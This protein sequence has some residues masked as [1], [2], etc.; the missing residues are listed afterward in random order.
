[1][2]CPFGQ[3]KYLGI[4]DVDAEEPGTMIAIVPQVIASGD[5]RPEVEEDANELMLTF[6]EALT[7]ESTSNA[8]SAHWIHK[9]T[10]CCFVINKDFISSPII[11]WSVS[12]Q[13]TPK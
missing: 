3:N 8:P 5:D 10:I 6:K 9:Q 13:T 12:I 2:L 11:D 1:M 7:A 4:A